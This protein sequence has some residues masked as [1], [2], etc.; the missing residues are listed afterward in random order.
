[1]EDQVI[2]K[3]EEKIKHIVDEDINANNL[4]H[5]YKLTKI[6][7]MAKEDKEMYRDY[8]GRGAGYDNYG[9]DYYRNYGNDYGRRGRDMR[10]RGEEE[11]DRMQGEYGNYQESRRYGAP[12]ET[13]KSFHYMVKAWRSWNTSTKTNA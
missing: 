4:D 1:M 9:R 10:Y 13:D 6:R 8:N 2:K 3:V 5:L 7:H 12:D 11:L